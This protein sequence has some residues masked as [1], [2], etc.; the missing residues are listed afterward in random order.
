M[1]DNVKAPDDIF[2]GTETGAVP[3][4]PP[5]PDVAIPP[6][7]EFAAEGMTEVRGKGMPWKVILIVIG[8]IVVVGGAAGISYALLA[9]DEPAAPVE[10]MPAA[11]STP[12]V[13]TAPVV[14]AAVPTMPPVAAPTTPPVAP[15]DSDKDGLTD[16]EE[17][18][19]GTSPSAAD[20]DA[21]GL[22]DKEETS[23]YETDPLNPDTDGDGYQDGAEV[24]GGYDPKGPGKLFE[25]PRN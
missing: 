17:A 2:A 21:D 10:P 18:K 5:M 3:P 4:P 19:L 12:S 11:A 15:A 9:S 14:P 7:A 25:V 6:V 23:T 24:K 13:P 1:F 16:A 20:T 22:F 8:V